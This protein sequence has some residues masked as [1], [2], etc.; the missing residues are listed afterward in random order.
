MPVDQLVEFDSMRATLD[1]VMEFRSLHRWSY[2]IAPLVA[3]VVASALG[4][5]KSVTSTLALLAVG[6]IVW[7]GFA[8]MQDSLDR[9]P[10]ARE[11]AQAE[12]ATLIAEHFAVS[13]DPHETSCLQTLID[14]PSARCSMVSSAGDAT[15]V[16]AVTDGQL[17]LESVGPAPLVP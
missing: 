14:L 8:H 2:A 15:Y 7:S 1:A 17:S 4:W 3:A 11:A 10:V 16:F 9:V 13:V 6:L 5:R 12:N